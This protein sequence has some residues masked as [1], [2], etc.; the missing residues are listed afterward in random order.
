M[1]HPDAPPMLCHLSDGKTLLS[2]HHNR[3]N[4]SFDIYKG[5]GRNPEAFQDRS[6]VWASL[7]TDE[8]RTWSEPRFVFV[9]ALAETLGSDFR[10]YQCSYIDVFAD[11]DTLNLFVPHR[12]RQVLHL[13]FQE[14]EITAFP[15]NAELG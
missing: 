14:S 13:Q 9:N 8:G 15:T 12:W 4:V 7:S 11:G 1:V 3:H 10:N 2:L 5:L 6:E